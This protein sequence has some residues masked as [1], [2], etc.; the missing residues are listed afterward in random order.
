MITGKEFE[1]MPNAFACRGPAPPKPTK[2]KSLGSNP[3]S[4]ETSL[5]APNID[6]FTILIIPSAAS[7]KSTP[8]PSAM[9]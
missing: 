1:R 2:A 3:C 8:M 6:S 5:N 9:V 4:T 7:I